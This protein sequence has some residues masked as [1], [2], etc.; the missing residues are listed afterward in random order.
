[1]NRNNIHSSDINRNHSNFELKRSSKSKLIAAM[2]F[3]REIKRLKK[4]RSE[5]WRKLHLLQPVIDWK[6][7]YFKGVL[8][9]ENGFTA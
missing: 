9:T 1:M 8:H 7:H 6:T 3:R 5:G 4:V 2:N